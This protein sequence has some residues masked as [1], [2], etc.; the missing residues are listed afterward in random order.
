M[1]LQRH[2][3]NLK[4]FHDIIKQQLGNKFIEV[5]TNDDPKEGH[6]LPHHLLLKN[7]STTPIRIVFN[8]SAKDKQNSVSLNDCLQAGPS[9]TQSLYDML[10]KFYIETYAYTTD[11]SMTFLR[12]AFDLFGATSSP[13]L[14]QA[15][16]LD[17]HLK[18]SNSPNKT[19][20]SNNLYV[21]SFQGTASSESKLLNKYD[22]ANRELLGANMPLQSWVSKQC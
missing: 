9:L 3:E 18:K 2:P 19:E 15:P 7:S 1:R 8:C 10:L 11:I 5:V 4:L 14:L 21:D 13:F 20:I 22:K 12:F 17:T 6:Y 16:F